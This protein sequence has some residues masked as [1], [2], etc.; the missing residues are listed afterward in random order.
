MRCRRCFPGLLAVA[1]G[2]SMPALAQDEQ[3]LIR[4]GSEPAAKAS[5]DTLAAGAESAPGADAGAVPQIQLPHPPSTVAETSNAS[6]PPIIPERDRG[7]DVMPADAQKWFLPPV[8]TVRLP[9][10]VQMG[11]SLSAAGILRLTGEVAAIDLR[12]D[13]PQDVAIPDELMLTLRSTVNVLPDAAAMTVIIND[14]PPVV[15]SLDHLTGFETV[16]IPATGLTAGT[17]RISIELRQPHRIYCG[18]EASFSVWTEIHLTQSGVPIDAA[19][20]AADTSGLA[21]ALRTQVAIGRVLPV[22]VAEDENAAVQ[23][24]LAEML[25]HATRGQVP[26][27]FRSF[28]ELGPPLPLSIA[29][30]ASDRS[31][32][33]LREGAAGGLVLQVEHSSGELPTLDE[34][35]PSLSLVPNSVPALAP[36]VTT[37][38]A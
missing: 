37:S 18:P 32:A 15:L 33:E 25:N 7:G 3:P 1:L 34:L 23:R 35:L 5:P 4:L 36:G 26:V 10:G 8:P 31:H 12:L 17:N 24:Q 21:M 20:I 6:T 19:V 9:A 27:Q 30:I 28:Y 38:L 22:L 11:A 13:V 29:L 2:L 14:A 16:G